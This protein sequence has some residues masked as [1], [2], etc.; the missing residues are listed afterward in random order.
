MK[1]AGAMGSVTSYKVWRNNEVRVSARQT[2]M[3]VTYKE[4]GSSSRDALLAAN[5][6][7]SMR[8]GERTVPGLEPRP[9]MSSYKERDRRN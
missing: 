7:P 4:Q 8:C 9:A 5:G 3:I 6:A 1:K 2:V